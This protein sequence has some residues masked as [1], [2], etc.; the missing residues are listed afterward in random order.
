MMTLRACVQRYRLTLGGQHVWAPYW[1]NSAE[2][3]F[4]LDAP[5]RGKGSAVELGRAARAAARAAGAR[6]VTPE[7]W[8]TLMRQHGLGIDCSGFAF[9]V[10]SD[11][12]AEA[13]GVVLAE[14]LVVPASEVRDRN[15]RHPELAERWRVAGGGA[16]TGSVTLAQACRMW[17]I[18]AAPIVGVRRLVDPAVVVAVSEVGLAQP[19]DLIAMSHDGSE[20]IGVVVRAQPGLL[21]YADSAHDRHGLGGVS[22]RYVA[23]DQ[24]KGDLGQQ[25]W[26]QKKFYHPEQPGSRDGLWRLRIL[27]QLTAGRA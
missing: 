22:W 20:H 25:S 21:T 8:R 3:P 23:V 6:P 18:D 10:L 26:G 19:G 1:L 27:A 5:L 15:R 7:D 12:L 2:A 14:H 13:Y 4:W 17:Q 16:V 24:P 11:W 9:H